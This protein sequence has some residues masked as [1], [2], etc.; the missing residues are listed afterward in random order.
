VRIALEHA[1]EA[2]ARQRLVVDDEDLQPHS[3]SSSRS[4]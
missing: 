4:V 2:L 3:A 1:P